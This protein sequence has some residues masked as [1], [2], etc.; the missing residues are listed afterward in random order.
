MSD[1]DVK[2]LEK[3]KQSNLSKLEALQ[4]QGLSL[5]VGDLAFIKMEALIDLTVTQPEAKLAL[6]MLTE[7]KKKEVLDQVFAEIRKAQL[8]QG[9]AEA[10][11][12]IGR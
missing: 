5:S 2:E 11:T 3:L 1:I 10:K 9:V 12:R 8:M 6:E 4:N 7:Q